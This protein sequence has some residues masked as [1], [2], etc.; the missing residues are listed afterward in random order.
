MI[1]ARRMEVFA[2]IFDDENNQVRDIMADVVDANIY[3]KYLDKKVLFFGD[4]AMKCQEMINHKNAT[5][6][7]GIFPSAKD[8]GILLCQKFE[9]KDFEDVAYFEPFYLK[10]FVA[11]KKKV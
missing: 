4:G 8:M 3:K 9:N 5:Y 6:L 10:D 11:G 2:A 1:D 7:E